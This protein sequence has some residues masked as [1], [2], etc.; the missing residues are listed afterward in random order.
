VLPYLN[1]VLGGHQYLADP[2]TLMLM[3]HGKL[4]T[5]HP[6]E[7]A[8]NAL[9]DEAEADRILEWLKREINETWAKRDSIE[10]SYEAAAAPRI[11]EILKLLP[12]TNCGE[13]GQPTC[14]VFAAVVAQGGREPKDCPPLPAENKKSLEAYLVR[15]QRP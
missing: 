10:P 14:I 5:L 1:T 9:K 15:F 2:P 4:I 7:I 3:S 8:V 6:K 13:C 12:L 11:L